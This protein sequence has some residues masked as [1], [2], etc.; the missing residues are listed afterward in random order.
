M[1]DGLIMR[2][3]QG[4]NNNTA[5]ESLTEISQMF[6]NGHL[7]RRRFNLD[8]STYFSEATL[9]PGRYLPVSL[10][11]SCRLEREGRT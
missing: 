11:W 10:T 6:G 1:N 3:R 9:I 2:C 5:T 8:H 4:Q 7:V